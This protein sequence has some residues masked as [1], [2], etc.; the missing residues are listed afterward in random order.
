MNKLEFY[1]SLGAEPMDDWTVYRITG[2]T[3]RNMSD[4][5]LNADIKNNI[6]KSV[7]EEYR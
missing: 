3:L 4:I 2:E 5:L 6:E 7:S 1:L